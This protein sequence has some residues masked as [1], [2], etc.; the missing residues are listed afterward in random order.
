MD[1][2]LFQKLYKKHCPTFNPLIAEGLARTHLQNPEEYIDEGIRCAAMDFPEG[3]TYRGY[4]VCTPHE[5]FQVARRKGNSNKVLYELSKSDI[6]L[7]KFF[8]EFNGE[9]L[10]E[11][12]LFLPYVRKAGLITIMGSTFSVSPVLADRGFSIGEKDIFIKLGRDRMTFRRHTHQFVANGRRESTSVIWSNIHHEF[13]KKTGVPKTVQM[14]CSLVHYLFCKFGLQ[15]AFRRFAGVDE[16]L[17]GTN[18]D[19]NSKN[20]PTDEW[21]I[22]GT[23]A[24]HKPRGTKGI[25]MPTTLT[26]AI[27]RRSWNQ[28]TQHLIGGLFYIADRFPDR[29]QEDYL[30][31]PKHWCRL[32]GHAIFGSHESEGKLLNKMDAHMT[33]LDGYVDSMVRENL[34]GVGVHVSDVYELFM[35]VIRSFAQRVTEG[36]KE[37]ASLYGKQLVITSYVLG[38]ILQQIN[39]MMFALQGAAKT[40]QL[41]R[42]DVEKTL[43]TYFKPLDIIKLNDKHPEVASVSSPSDCMAFKV[44]A[45]TV[46]QSNMGGGR[47]NKSVTVDAS[48]KL[49]ASI[50]EVGQYNNLQKGEPS[51]RNRL[52]PCLTLS[53]DLTTI[54][55]DPNKIDLIDKTQRIISQ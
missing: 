5:A 37:V 55:R 54:V 1:N 6:F 43:R 27:P 7:T 20:Y 41:T 22:C 2:S 18:A 40:K 26:V 19:I 23:A 17:V 10:K 4:Q 3:I 21:V 11:Q 15:E 46:L 25:Y 30:S 16:M 34:T 45:I 44:T 53:A 36:A 32:M 35:H 50:A 38:G 39:K 9:P 29:M 49:H 13:N 52:N 14:D 12:Y 51:G 31:D 48:K 47:R 28:D 42:K 33:S 24:D 8:F